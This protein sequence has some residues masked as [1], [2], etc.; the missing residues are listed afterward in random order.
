MNEKELIEQAR[1]V[2]NRYDHFYESIN[3]KGNLYLAINA[4][5]IGGIASSYSFL[6]Q[7]LNF[8]SGHNVVIAGVVILC[9][10]SLSFTIAAINPFTKSS[11][12]PGNVSLIHYSQVASLE[13]KY[14]ARK[15]RNRSESMH[16]Q[17]MLRQVHIL[18]VG[19]TRKFE[20]LKYAGWVLSFSLLLLV[21]LS[22]YFIVK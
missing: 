17:D 19:L 15:F 12:Q 8:S 9:A 6:D 21:F 10:V 22:L 4:I 7:K 20:R 16:L 13:C 14:Y 11:P 3:T 5:L 2:I 18:S 1:F